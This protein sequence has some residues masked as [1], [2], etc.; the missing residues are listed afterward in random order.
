MDESIYLSALL[1]LH[2][3]PASET[4]DDKQRR[5]EIVVGCKGEGIDAATATATVARDGKSLECRGSIFRRWEGGI[6][7][8]EASPVTIR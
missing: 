1:G 8:V 7:Q 6:G 3:L 4:H 5:G 2:V